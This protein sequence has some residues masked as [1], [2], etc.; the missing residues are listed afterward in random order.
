[1]KNISLKAPK[2]AALKN[3]VS[4]KNNIAMILQTRG[5]ARVVPTDNFL[6]NNQITTRR[7]YKII[8]G[9]VEM[10]LSEAYAFANWLGVTI[11]EL[12]PSSNSIANKF[13]LSL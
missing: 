7:F 13:N 8:D 2:K 3:T 1:M 12:N 10:K 9:K 5:I 4:A 11:D 6:K